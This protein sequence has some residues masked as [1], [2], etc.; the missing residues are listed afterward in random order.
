[1]EELGL[2]T[3]SFALVVWCSTNWGSRWL[4]KILWHTL[5]VKFSSDF[6]VSCKT[7]LADSDSFSHSV[8]LLQ[9]NV[10]NCLRG[11]YTCSLEHSFMP[12]YRF[13]FA[14]DFFPLHF[15]C[16]VRVAYYLT[17]IVWCVFFLSVVNNVY[18][19]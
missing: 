15:Q 14:Y 12:Y 19:I 18:F 11:W 8:S 13:L 2:E 3:N 5:K 7:R 6:C 4:I 9:V 1:M 17:K 16:Q 10:L